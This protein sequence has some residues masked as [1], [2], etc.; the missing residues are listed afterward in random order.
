MKSSRIASDSFKSIVTSNIY[1]CE[2]R[3]SIM[4]AFVWR[5]KCYK[6]KMKF[7]D[8]Y[9]DAVSVRLIVVFLRAVIQKKIVLLIKRKN[10]LKQP[11]VKT[12]QNVPSSPEIGSDMC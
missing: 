12:A 3:E 7:I 6:D 1:Q 8:S 9:T 5:D 2:K 11:S 4:E 10:Y